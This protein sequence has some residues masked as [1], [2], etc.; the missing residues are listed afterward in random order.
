MFYEG[1]WEGDR[2]KYGHDHRWDRGRD[3]DYNRH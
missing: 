1:Y 3:R 2:G